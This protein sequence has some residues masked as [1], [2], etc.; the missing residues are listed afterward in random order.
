VNPHFPAESGHF[1]D[2]GLQYDK[3]SES[4]ITDLV[5][6]GYPSPYFSLDIQGRTGIVTPAS[7]MAID[8]A[9]SY[10]YDTRRLNKSFSKSQM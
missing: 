9:W 7:K 2:I 4:P 6:F 8:V 5:T 3:P 1:E 10:C